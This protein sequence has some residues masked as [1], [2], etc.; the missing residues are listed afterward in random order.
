MMN[1]SK[2]SALRAP[3]RREPPAKARI[4]IF[5]GCKNTPANASRARLHAESRQIR[6]ASAG[7]VLPRTFESCQDCLVRME[8][9]LPELSNFAGPP[10]K[11][12]VFQEAI[13]RAKGSRKNNFTFCGSVFSRRSCLQKGIGSRILVR[14]PP[15]GA[16]R[17]TGICGVAAPRRCHTSPASRRLASARPALA[18]ECELILARTLKSE[19]T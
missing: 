17:W 1:R 14:L 11:P 4:A 8:N 5:G 16:R 12:G 9:R 2:R 3:D 13:I 10:A 15:C 7:S 18:P 6:A 19:S